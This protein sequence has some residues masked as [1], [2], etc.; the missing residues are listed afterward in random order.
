MI[1]YIHV[2][3]KFKKALIYSIDKALFEHGVL[4]AMMWSYVSRPQK[5]L[6]HSSST[7]ASWLWTLKLAPACPFAGMRAHA[8]HS[9]NLCPYSC[10]CASVRVHV[11]IVLQ[12]VSVCRPTH[13]SFFWLSVANSSL[14]PFI[15]PFHACPCA[16][17]RVHSRPC[18]IIRVHARHQY[19]AG[20]ETPPSSNKNWKLFGLCDHSLILWLP[21]LLILPKDCTWLEL[22]TAR[23]GPTWHSW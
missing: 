23:L 8:L 18:A 17:V 9:C 1:K 12:C 11:L 4:M 16:G 5:L 3:Q 21:S 19:A 6:A 7:M 2:I 13:Y 10:P 22:P 20:V 15:S 14:E